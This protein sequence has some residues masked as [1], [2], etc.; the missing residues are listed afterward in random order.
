M[1]SFC[2]LLTLIV[3]LVARA[4]D[5]LQLQAAVTMHDSGSWWGFSKWDP[6]GTYGGSESRT[7]A[8]SFNDTLSIVGDSTS[9]S[10]SQSVQNRADTATAVFDRI[11]TT[12]RHLRI[13]GISGGGTDGET[14]HFTISIDSLP[15]QQPA[16]SVLTVV[17][18]SYTSQTT[19]S[20]SW[21]H[22]GGPEGSGGNLTQ[23]SGSGS[24]S[25]PTAFDVPTASSGVRVQH[26]NSGIRIYSL[27]G[28]AVQI[29]AEPSGPN[30]PIEIFDDLGRIVYRANFDGGSVRLTNLR[31][32]CYFAR[33][34]GTCAKF[35]VSE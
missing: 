35:V 11:T 10:V 16:G 14:Y 17:P 19:S 25:G 15:I 28:G 13:T 9:Q 8:V 27:T 29:E 18:G 1:K 23:S 31:A 30:E 2:L 26:S 34:G 6:T 5:R 24:G 3:P 22:P 21:T 33:L 7:F 32:G 12:I 20:Y 4:Q